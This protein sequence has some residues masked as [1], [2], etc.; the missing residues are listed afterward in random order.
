ML[1][2][3]SEVFEDVV[4][5]DLL[6]LVRVYSGEGVHVNDCILEADQRKAKGSLQSLRNGEHYT[7]HGSC[8]M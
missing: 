6:G 8:K 1:C 7:A 2:Y 4:D 5:D 3:F